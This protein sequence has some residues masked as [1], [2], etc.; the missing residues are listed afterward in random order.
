MTA[1]WE[2]ISQVS[3]RAPHQQPQQFGRYMMA[4]NG[5]WMGS[6]MGN[7]AASLSV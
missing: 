6:C 4:K 1:A 2:V 3:N 5:G 7:N